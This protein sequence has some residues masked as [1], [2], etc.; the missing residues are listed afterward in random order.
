MYISFEYIISRT[1]FSLRF[2]FDNDLNDEIYTVSIPLGSL[3]GWFWSSPAL[4]TPG[5]KNPTVLK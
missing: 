2:D 1:N 4:S 5:E 3:F